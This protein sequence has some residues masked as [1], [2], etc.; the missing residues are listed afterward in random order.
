MK[1]SFEEKGNEVI[2]RID[3]VEKKYSSILRDCYYQQAGNT[4]FKNFLKDSKDLS[5]IQH[6]FSIYANEMFSQAGYFLT[7]PWEKALTE[8]IER[9]NG[10]K[11]TWWL[12]GSCAACIRGI[13]MK[14]HDID[15]M[16]DSKNVADIHQLFLDCIVEPILDRRGWVTKDFGVIFLHARI[17]IASDPQP[18]ADKPTPSDFGPYAQ[19]HLE[20][21]TWK[22]YQIMVP[23][24]YLYL[25]AAKRRGRLERVNLIEGYLSK[26]KK[27]QTI[28][29]P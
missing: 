26:N 22:E 15:I 10:S 29:E 14:P 16:I 2:F 19:Q 1:I 8:F 9:V 4:Y 27:G 6:N 5:I 12:V 23:P 28:Q 7:I 20:K 25:D 18:A 11:I 24:L 3:N 13:P 21:V 17:D